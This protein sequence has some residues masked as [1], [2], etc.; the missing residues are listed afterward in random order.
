M[1]VRRSDA[2]QTLARRGVGNES[3][4]MTV[5]EGVHERCQADAACRKARERE[6]AAILSNGVGELGMRIAGGCA[7]IEH[8]VA[9]L[10]RETLNP[11]GRA[12]FAPRGGNPQRP[13]EGDRPAGVARMGHER[14][15]LRQHS[16]RVVDRRS[17]ADADLLFVQIDE[18]ERRRAAPVAI[19]LK[20]DDC[21]HGD[22]RTTDG[23]LTGRLAERSRTPGR[24]HRPSGRIMT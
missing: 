24:C 11:F 6:D 1:A 2:V 21:V 23:W 4:A 14:T 19:I 22:G 18:H 3:G 10:R 20:I 17:V 15:A 8:H 9:T 7:A 13:H 5:M 16:D 12:G